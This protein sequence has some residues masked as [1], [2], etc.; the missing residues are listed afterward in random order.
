MA[1]ERTDPAAM[2]DKELAPLV[3]QLLYWMFMER[4]DKI[5]ANRR[6]LR[7]YEAIDEPEL[8]PSAGAGRIE[9]DVHLTSNTFLPVITGIIDT[10]K[11]MIY[12]NLWGSNDY[13]K[14]VSQHPEDEERAIFA[15]RHL[16]NRH[17]QMGFQT[18][19]AQDVIFEGLLYGTAV[20]VTDWKIEDGYEA[21]QQSR[22]DEVFTPEGIT[23]IRRTSSNLFY[24]QNAVDRVDTRLIEQNLWFPDPNADARGF[25]KVFCFVQDISPDELMQN[26]RTKDNPTGIYTFNP[27]DISTGIANLFDGATPLAREIQSAQRAF[28]MNAPKIGRQV[29]LVTMLWKDYM[30]VM[31]GNGTIIRRK[32]MTGWPIDKWNFRQIPGRF[33]GLGLPDVLERMAYDV[34]AMVNNRRD[35]E[36][37]IL[38]PIMIMEEELLSNARMGNGEL[39]PGQIYDFEGGGTPARDKFGIVQPGNPLGND[40]LNEM[41]LS[42]GIMHQISGVGPNAQGQFASGR[43]SATEADAVKQALQTNMG[44]SSVMLE[45]QWVEPT[46]DKQMTLERIHLNEEIAFRDQG[47]LDLY[48]SVTPERLAFRHNPQMQALG[49]THIIEDATAKA[50]FFQAVNIALHPAFE[51]KA[52]LDEI[53]EELWRMVKPNDHYRF[54]SKGAPSEQISIPPD[55]EHLLISNGHFPNVAPGDD[56]AVH[57]RRHLIWKAGPGY[58]VLPPQMKRALDLHIGKHEQAQAEKQGGGSTANRGQGAAIGGAIQTQ[59]SSPVAETQVA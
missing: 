49:T 1:I 9:D 2:T 16:R 6:H 15:C 28:A 35:Y 17:K 3:K 5:N 20:S 4:R 57:L 30:C 8:R 27:D 21:G 19:V 59:Q 44:M 42:M 14:C 38:N 46:Y 7:L 56:H 50:Q 11:T 26:R 58:Q 32:V 36:N 13:I 41:N 52:N 24:K 29:H 10:A 55:Q 34:N 53:H 54:I 18:G 31:T 37:L 39:I 43:R 23:H 12:Q 22:I 47:E 40:M 48:V 33:N 25:G 51:G 45:R